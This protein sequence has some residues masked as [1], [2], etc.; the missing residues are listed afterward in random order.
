MF[1]LFGCILEIRNYSK[2]FLE[3]N[4]HI[5]DFIKF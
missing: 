5:V 1:P 2:A 4:L 3:A